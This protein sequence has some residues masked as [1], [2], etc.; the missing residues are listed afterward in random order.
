[1]KHP[2]PWFRHFFLLIPIMTLIQPQNGMAQGEQKDTFL[3]ESEEPI[4][5]LELLKIQK[6]PVKWWIRNIG[7]V[8]VVVK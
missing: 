8:K 1:M 4:E 6:V 2:S 7:K 5:P 3:V